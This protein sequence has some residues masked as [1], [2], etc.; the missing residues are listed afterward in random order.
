MGSWIFFFG[1]GGTHKRKVQSTLQL[2]QRRILKPL[3]HTEASW[4]FFFL[5]CLFCMLLWEGEKIVC[6]EFPGGLAG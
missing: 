1:E 2:R 4:I 6:W 3:H 5:I